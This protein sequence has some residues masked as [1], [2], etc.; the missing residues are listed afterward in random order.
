MSLLELL[1][2]SSILALVMA[3]ISVVLRTSRQ[4][5]EAHEAEHARMEAAHATLRHI[6]REVRQAD[7]VTDISSPSNNSGRLALRLP[8]GDIRVWQHDAVTDTVRY[9]LGEADQLLAPDVTGLRFVGLRTDAV[10]AAGLPD[11]V[12]CLRIEVTI[13]LP[14]ET[15]GTRVISSWAWVRSW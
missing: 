12:Q 15:N 14:R 4:A 3:S 13:E 1:I 7:A 6:V 10:T 8:G 2:A 9:G 5:W 11:D